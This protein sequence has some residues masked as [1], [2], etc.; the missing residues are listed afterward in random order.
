MD[1]NFADLFQSRCPFCRGT[2]TPR[3]MTV[4]DRERTIKFV[5]DACQRVWVSGDLPSAPRMRTAVSDTAARP[6]LSRPSVAS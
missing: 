2:R 4:R 6:Y 3:D 1:A 5:C